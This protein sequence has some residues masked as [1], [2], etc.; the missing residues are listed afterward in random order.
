M[1]DRELKKL[2]RAELLE[3]LLEES[4]ENE[5]LRAKLRKARQLLE[6]KQDQ[7]DNADS[8][9]DAALQ[10]NGVLE[11]AEAAA[12]QYLENVRRMAE[13]NKQELGPD[14]KEETI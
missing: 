5:R 8:L 6:E 10:L 4:R 2:G 11:A 7:I 3:L 12:E 13:D 14:W 1:A 9:A